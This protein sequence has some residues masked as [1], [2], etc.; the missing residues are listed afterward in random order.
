MHCITKGVP[1]NDLAL[2]PLPAYGNEILHDELQNLKFLQI[3][4]DS[5]SFLKE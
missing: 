5:P 4:L 3:F 1:A 2:I